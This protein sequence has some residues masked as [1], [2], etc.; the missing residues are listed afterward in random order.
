[1]RSFGWTKEHLRWFWKG[2]RQLYEIAYPVS[3]ER[4]KAT[5]PIKA[6]LYPQLLSGGNK[7]ADRLIEDYA[8]RFYRPTAAATPNATP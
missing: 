3:N 8:N 4:I 6:V 7:L 5:S 2:C 1:M